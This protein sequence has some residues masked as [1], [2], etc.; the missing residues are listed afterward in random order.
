MRGIATH[1][2]VRTT[3]VYY[4]SK[5]LSKHEYDDQSLLLTFQAMYATTSVAVGMQGASKAMG[6]MNK[7]L[8]NF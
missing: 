8:K 7:V 3:L 1:T 2:Q 4:L 6:A 5:S